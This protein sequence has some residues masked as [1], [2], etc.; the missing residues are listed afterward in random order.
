MKYLYPKYIIDQTRFEATFSRRQFT[1]S[2]VIANLQAELKESAP[3]SEGGSDSESEDEDIPLQAKNAL[4]MKITKVLLSS[5]DFGGEKK[6]KNRAKRLKSKS[7]R[8]ASKNRGSFHLN[9]NLNREGKGLQ[10]K[11]E[12]TLI[13]PT[14]AN[15]KQKKNKTKQK[16][17]ELKQE[18]RTTGKFRTGVTRKLSFY[19]GNN[20]IPK[21]LRDRSTSKH[22][23]LIPKKGA[24]LMITPASLDPIPKRIVDNDPSSADN[25]L[26]E[27][28]ENT[29]TVQL[30]EPILRED[31]YFIRG[32][33]AGRLLDNIDR[34]KEPVKKLSRIAQK[35]NKA[36]NIKKNE[37][38]N[39]NGFISQQEIL[40][41][42][43]VIRSILHRFKVRKQGSHIGGGYVI[44]PLSSQK[45][46]DKEDQNKFSNSSYK[47][48]ATL[49][50]RSIR[51][52]MGDRD[53][54]MK[55]LPDIYKG[56]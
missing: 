52:R 31:I 17:L 19:G 26:E 7:R 51:S 43:M 14:E 6:Q 39:L 2:Q 5:M 55:R 8:K 50:R 30:Y 38:E 15:Q 48:H 37:A 32:L 25:G 21:K 45:G 4:K 53:E 29:K 3:V 27:Q 34:K 12:N 9:N 23:T 56:F 40:T 36:L 10:L 54:K 49:G 16:T 1:L 28:S 18:K 24:L 47:M 22:N 33:G 11:S 20:E 13:S 46:L 42:H 41:N 44:Q 35:V